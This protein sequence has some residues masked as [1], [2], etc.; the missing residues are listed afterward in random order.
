MLAVPLS[1]S[2]QATTPESC[3]K[4]SYAAT[5]KIHVS[6][7]GYSLLQA[8]VLLASSPP[9]FVILLLCWRTLSDN[10]SADALL[11]KLGSMISTL[12]RPKV[13]LSEV[14]CQPLNYPNGVYIPV[15]LIP[16]TI[17]LSLSFRELCDFDCGGIVI[18]S[19]LF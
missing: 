19:D 14:V 3:L 6:G 18:N 9:T 1:R 16:V 7:Y 8:D 2:Y 10:A 11:Q 5:L 15:L 4:H 17:F 13:M 12:V